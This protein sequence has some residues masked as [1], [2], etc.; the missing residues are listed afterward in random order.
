VAAITWVLI[1][2]EAVLGAQLVMIATTDEANSEGRN[3]WPSIKRI[4]QHSR[5]SVRNVKTLLPKLEKSGELRIR[6]AWSAK[7][8]NATYYGLWAVPAGV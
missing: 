8:G 1:N 2:S 7:A 3:A 6:R 5:F 4:A